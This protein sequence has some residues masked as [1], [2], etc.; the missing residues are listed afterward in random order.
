MHGLSAREEVAADLIGVEKVHEDHCCSVYAESEEH[1]GCQVGTL[2]PGP[3][4]KMALWILGFSEH[5]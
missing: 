4:E 5:R 1:F 2:A 3:V